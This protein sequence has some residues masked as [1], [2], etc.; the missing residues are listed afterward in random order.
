MSTSC[1]VKE[2]IGCEE[3]DEPVD[4]CVPVLSTS[5]MTVH[6]ILNYVLI[7]QVI[8]CLSQRTDNL[9]ASM[10]G[11][12]RVP[13]FGCSQKIFEQSVENFV[14]EVHRKIA[15]NSSTVIDSAIM[16]QI[17]GQFFGYPTTH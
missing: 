10:N 6:N 1:V 13:P 15:S 14:H 3:S 12:V 9:T 8:K 16:Y 2:S 11:L 4:I 7:E 5:S 17:F